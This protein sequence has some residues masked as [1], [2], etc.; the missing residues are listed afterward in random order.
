MAPSLRFLIDYVL[1]EIAL[2]GAQ[3]AS[4]SEVLTFIDTFYSKSNNSQRNHAVDR[5]FQ[6]KVWSWLARNPEVSVGRD[7]QGNHLSLA[8]VQL[9]YTIASNQSDTKSEF[10]DGGEESRASPLRLFVSEERTWRAITGHEPDETKVLPTEFTLLSV[11]ASAKSSGIIQPELV[12]ISGQDKRS[13]PKRTNMLHKK[14]YIIKSPIHIRGTRTSLCTLSKFFRDK[15]PRQAGETSAG[16]TTDMIQ[17]GEYI[18]FDAFLRNMFS[19]LREYRLI[20][21]SD[22][23][24]MLGFTDAW[25]MRILSRAL[26]K[27]ERIGVLKRVRAMS[28]YSGTKKSFYSCV[29]LVRDPSARDFALFNEYGQNLVAS[30]KENRERLD[31]DNDD[32]DQD[33][34]AALD[35]EPE[36]VV[37]RESDVVDTGRPLPTWTPD[38]SF[39]NQIFDTVDRERT[40]GL[41]SNNILR[42]CFGE[43]F[44]KPLESMLVRLVDCW[45]LAQPPHLRHFAIV[46]DTAVAHRMTQYVHYTARNFQLLV[47][48]G[49]ASWEAVEYVRKKDKSDPPHVPP[50]DAVPELDT[51]GLPLIT[52]TNKLVKNGNATLLECIIAGHPEDYV[53]SNSDAIPVQRE[54][55]TYTLCHG[56]SD[57]QPRA[58]QRVNSANYNKANYPRARGRPKGTPSKRK[59]GY[60]DISD[61]SIDEAAETEYVKLRRS[62]PLTREERFQGLPEKERLEA[63]GLDESWTEYSVLLM[64]RHTPGVYITQRGRRR[65]AGKKQGRPRISRLA[66]FKSPKLYSFDWFRPEDENHGVPGSLESPT[67]TQLGEY[68]VADRRSERQLERDEALAVPSTPIGTRRRKVRPDS[69]GVE[70]ARGP[71]KRRRF[72][73]SEEVASQD[74]TESTALDVENNQQPHDKVDGFANEAPVTRPKKR[75]RTGNDEAQTT[76][77]HGSINGSIAGPSITAPE[78]PRNGNKTQ[79]H[80]EVEVPLAKKLRCESMV[81]VERQGPA[82][83]E[84][85][86]PLNNAITTGDME[87]TLIAQD[88]LRHS[89]SI[90]PAEEMHEPSGTHGH[91][92]TPKPQDYRTTGSVALMRRKIVIDIVDKAGGAFPMGQEL[93][94]P[95]TT[96]WG[97]LRHKEVPDLRTIKTVVKRLVD[98]GKLR[99]MTFSGRDNKGVMVKKTMITKAELHPD[100]PVIKDL[101]RSMLA[102]PRLYFPPNTEIDPALF[103][104][105]ERRDIP[106][107]T[108]LT[109]HLHQKPAFVLKNEEKKG[110][111]I[112]EQLLRSLQPGSGDARQGRTGVVRLMKIQR[113]SAHDPS[114]AAPTSIARPVPGGVGG[115]RIPKAHRVPGVGDINLRRVKRLWHPISTIAPYAMFMNPSQTFHPST[116]T[117][118]TD[119]GVATLQTRKVVRDKKGPSLPESLHDLL[120]RVRQRKRSSISESDIQPYDKFAS[121]SDKILRWELRNEELLHEKSEHLK[122]INQTVQDSFEAAQIEGNIR[123][124]NEVEGRSR[125]PNQPMTTRREARRRSSANK[126]TPFP[127][128]P[129]IPHEIEALGDEEIQDY[130]TQREQITPKRTDMIQGRRLTKLYES[131]NADELGTGPSATP[132]QRSI[133]RRRFTLPEYV[134]KKILTAIVVVR[135]LAGGYDGRIVDW[136]IVP[137]AFPDHDPT[138]IQDRG[139][140]LMNRNR[141]Q[142]IKM[143]SDFQ[144]RFIKAYANN[145]VPSINYED[146]EGYDWEGVVDWANTH[147]ETPSSQKLPDLPATRDQF[148]SLFELREETILSV[149]E[150]YQIT[151]TVSLSRRRALQAAVAL[152]VPFVPMLNRRQPELSRLEVAKTWVRA[153]VTTPE[154][155]YQSAEAYK[156]LS[157]LGE[158]L[159]ESA[160][161]SLV[162]DR[163]ISMTNRGR[164]TPGRNYD[165]TEHFLFTLGRRRAIEHTQLRRAAR[166][167]T[168][169]LDPELQARGSVDLNYHADDGDIL[170]LINL[171]AARKLTLKPRDPPN[172]KFGLTEGGYVT[173][174]VDKEKLRFSVEIH[175]VLGK[176]VYGNPVGGK[177]VNLP[178]PSPP[179]TAVVS[180]TLSLP[181]KIPIWVDI[182]GQFNKLLWDQVV[183]A[184]AGC[185]AIRPGISAFMITN[186][187]QPTMGL[188]E[189]KILLEWMK[190]VGVAR[191]ENNGEGEQGSGWRVEEWWW[192][193][194]GS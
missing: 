187:I 96:A 132:T 122:Y 158:P 112:R 94:Y 48:A 70:F 119:A 194:L 9:T 138:S 87:S 24:R 42:L 74:V 130:R 5:L 77:A 159:I 156:A 123:F 165:V 46:R 52:T 140:I 76:E 141:L 106:V 37:K 83:T 100:D 107:E 171:A 172:D 72:R 8:D 80:G 163:A 13:V 32:F 26:R 152:A 103:K 105:P 169:S 99:Q 139:K 150:L 193:V 134:E 16:L 73:D 183:A 11:I 178:P 184:I 75:Q 137:R 161:Q 95:F 4:P 91:L 68:T 126:Q 153:N 192:M 131:A 85:P 115:K 34:T 177:L 20:S 144:E 109:V 104:S 147:L 22:L 164:V 57:L 189:V 50:I 175:P 155:T 71:Y 65:P 133:V 121:E 25:R 84:H 39:H 58:L 28:Q 15:A 61:L 40:L 66:V 154:E 60:Q 190:K 19:I 174:Q 145:E 167:K 82:A 124:D 151:Q 23:K 110:R 89:E 173:R 114:V 12:K 111:R 116:G 135:A 18:D 98:S 3:G 69:P 41:T 44:H 182:H 88:R 30:L 63:M 108:G 90:K 168:N 79:T 86:S 180:P 27:L 49:Q 92:K 64:E 120:G 129:A 81:P 10:L 35:M 47:D 43:F 142:L 93:W 176:Y 62:R 67:A 166:F 157:L 160:L 14:G 149:D 148:D 101:Q 117:F 33:D 146:L 2:C 181:E 55:G 7:K 113:G 51:Y 188:W 78:E 36:A 136:N 21:R 186:M 53:R 128:Q 170:A 185:V 54:D 1:N 179:R 191:N 125:T 162:T 56:F 29:M 143:Q 97:K 102:A 31:M 127:P 6:E 59:Q 38:R 17:A 45:Q 118:S